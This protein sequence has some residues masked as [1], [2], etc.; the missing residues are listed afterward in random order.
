MVRLMES[1]VISA[2]EITIDAK[3]FPLAVFTFQ[4]LAILISVLTTC[5]A[6]RMRSFLLT[7]LITLPFVELG[8]YFGLAPSYIGFFAY[9]AFLLCIF[10]QSLIRRKTKQQATAALPILLSILI[11]ASAAIST[12][13]L[14]VI[15][16]KRPIKLSIM[17]NQWIEGNLLA[18]LP[19]PQIGGING[20]WLFAVGNR[21]T[22][23]KTALTVTMPREKT[24]VYLRGFSG[25]TYSSSRWKSVS[26]QTWENDTILS[27]SLSDA[28]LSIFDFQSLLA[29]QNSTYQKQMRIEPKRANKEYAYVPY[30]IYPDASIKGVT[31]SYFEPAKQVYLLTYGSDYSADSSAVKSKSYLQNPEQLSSIEDAYYSFLY[32][33]YLT[34]PK[35]GGLKLREEAKKLNL[36]AD[37]SEEDIAAAI[38]DYISNQ[39]SYSLTPGLTPANKDFIDYFLYENKKGYCVHFATAATLML[40]MYGIPSRY[41]EGYIITD[42][43]FSSGKKADGDDRYTMKISDRNAHA[44][45]EYYIKGKGWLPLETTPGYH[46]DSAILKEIPEEAQTNKEAAKAPASTVDTS[47]NESTS[48]QASTEDTKKNSTKKKEGHSPAA[49]L[50]APLILSLRIILCAAVLALLYLLL[51]ESLHRFQFKMQDTNQSAIRMDSYLNHLIQAAKH[52]PKEVKAPIYSL[53]EKARFSQHTLTRDEQQQLFEFVADYRKSLLHSKSF[54]VRI[55]VLFLP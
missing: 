17:R 30:A 11:F 26:K 52:D 51:M 24:T 47:S 6:G 5:F 41:V 19:I 12:Y 45:T 4:R 53:I 10:S 32:D 16:Y 44:W 28:G 50:P 14:Q 33:N 55:K 27:K 46:A 40:R 31:D 34:L 22:D 39:A 48:S 2:T 49:I 13:T 35:N 20:G 42:K 37:F 38:Q 29:N 54:F 23:G 18:V 43:D 9:A 8:L 3:A 25:G 15:D 21:K 7:L 36:P 1:R